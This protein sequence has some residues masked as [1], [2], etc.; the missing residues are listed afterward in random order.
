VFCL[1]AAATP[2]RVPFIL[3]AA[4]IWYDAI[5]DLSARIEASP[6]DTQLR[7]QRAAQLEQVGLAAV[8]R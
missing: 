1:L 5:G 2:A 6:G 3:A 4:G 8:G 7:V